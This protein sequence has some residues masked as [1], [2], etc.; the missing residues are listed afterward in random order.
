MLADGFRLPGTKYQLDIVK[1]AFD[2]GTMIR[3]LDHNDAFPG[4]EWGHPSDNIGAILATA[5]TFT[6]A[7]KTSGSGKI[8]TMKDVLIALMKAYEIQGC[9][10][11]KNAFNKVG[12]DH[13]ILVKV[14]ATTMVSWLMGLSKE[15]A[16]SAVSHAW[17]DGHPLRVYRQAPNTGPRKGWAGGDAC[18]RSR[19]PRARFPNLVDS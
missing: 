3:Y 8:L 4:A 18:S 9:F 14:A 5:D 17:A 11:I 2:L 6:R 13:V 12:L 15:E 7:A 1:G 16:M 19:S 10:Q